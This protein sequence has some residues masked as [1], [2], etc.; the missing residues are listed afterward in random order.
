MSFFK[1]ILKTCVLLLLILNSIKG[2]SQVYKDSIPPKMEWFANAKLGIFIHW[3]IYAVNGTSESWSFHNRGKSYPYY[4]NQIKGFKAE[5]YNPEQWADLIKESGARY[6]VITTQHHDGV[7]LWD[8]KQLTPNTLYNSQKGEPMRPG[9]KP[10]WNPKKPL[11]IPAQSP[12]KKDVISPF[13]KAIRARGLKF[14]AY[15]SLLDWSHN[16]YNGFFKDETRYQLKDDSVRW[17]RF[18]KFMHAQINEISNEFNP[19]L[20]WFDG[21]WEHSEEEWNAKK[22]ASDIFKKNPNAILNGRLKT[23]GDYHT[24]EQN[25]PVTRPES[26]TW[27]LCMTSNDNWGWRPDDTLM[28]TSNQVIRT[29][30]ECLGMGGN[31]LIDIGPKSDGT[32]TPEQTQLLKDLGRWT[33][34]HAEAIYSTRQGLPAGHFYGPSTLSLDSQTLF[35]FITDVRKIN[36]KETG[37]P[38]T[39]IMLKGLRNEVISAE[40]IGSNKPLKV[41]EMGKISWSS[42]PGTLFIDVPN[43][44]L[45]EEVTVVKLKLKGSLSLYRGKGGF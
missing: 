35:L 17:N 31:L 6:V 11:S 30:A 22:I 8:T 42:V 38:Q 9:I 26:A 7:A 20:F 43:N 12:C 29:F 34:K 2:F 25:M 4:M 45:D 15:Y 5:N 24:P 23:Y 1:T 27:E 40:V 37:N 32:I 41:V 14:G 28:K 44:D 39:N 36:D 19:D 13:E 16:D 3:G 10:L 18:L 21:D 33:K